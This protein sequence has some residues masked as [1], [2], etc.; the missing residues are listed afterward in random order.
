MAFPS[1]PGNGNDLPT[2]EIK[3][4]GGYYKGHYYPCQNEKKFAYYVDS[5]KIEF[6]PHPPPWNDYKPDFY[7]PEF[8]L[9]VEVKLSKDFLWEVGPHQEEIE[10]SGQPWICVAPLLW[11]LSSY[12]RVSQL[13]FYC[14]MRRSRVE[15]GIG[16]DGS[17][18]GPCQSSSEEPS[19]H[20]N[21][22][23]RLCSGYLFGGVC[24]GIIRFSS[25]L[26]NRPT[27][28]PCPH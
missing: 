16:M 15:L 9:T 23:E 7:L 21:P 4:Q 22:G 13:V 19:I 17:E 8:H 25:E 28:Y 20:P 26:S 3:A 14:L 1:F 24:L 18:N 2:R 5:Q 10:N 6:V 11:G 27:C 12:Q